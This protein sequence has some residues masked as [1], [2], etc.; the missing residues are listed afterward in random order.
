MKINKGLFTSQTD[1]WETPQHV[2]DKLNEEF[3][4]TLDVCATEENAKC[5]QYFTKETD[6][7]LQQWTPNRCFMNPPYG[8]QIKEWIKKAYC[9]S[10]FGALVV[11]LIPARTDTRWWHRFVMESSEIRFIKGRLKFGK[12][13][14]GAPFP[15]C[16]VIF[17][18]DPSNTPNCKSVQF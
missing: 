15:S 1:E 14:Q 4:F 13:K 12:S 7:L 8:R 17:K 11:C 2:F 10:Q 9:A 3:N 5:K 18:P 6:G 16:I